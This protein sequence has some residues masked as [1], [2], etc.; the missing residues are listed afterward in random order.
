VHSDIVLFVGRGPGAFNA[1]HWEFEGTLGTSSRS[2]YW[3][4]SNHGATFAYN[5]LYAVVDSFDT[6]YCIGCA[7]GLGARLGF[8]DSIGSPPVLLV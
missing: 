1:L 5:D 2:S 8:T 7:P 4:V 6:L 3:P